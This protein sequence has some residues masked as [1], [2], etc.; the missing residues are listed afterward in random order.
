MSYYD[1]HVINNRATPDNFCL[2][3]HALL[4]P[5]LFNKQQPPIDWIQINF[6]QNLNNRNVNFEVYT[7]SNYKIGKNN[8]ILSRLACINSKIPLNWLNKEINSYK[9]LCKEKF[10]SC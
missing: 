7:N 3:K 1:L 10:L 6:N 5:S 9:I 4:L 2:Y 8:K